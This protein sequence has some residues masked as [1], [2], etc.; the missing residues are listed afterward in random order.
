MRGLLPAACCLGATAAITMGTLAEARAQTGAGADTPRFMIEEIVVTARRREERLIDVPVSAT[1]FSGEEL[2][3]YNNV[4]LAEIGTQ[5]PN[6]NFI[7]IGSGSGATLMIRGLGSTSAEAGIEQSVI[8]NLDGIPM[9]R[10]RITRFSLFDLEALEV[11]KGPQ[12]LFFG[13]NSSAGV[14]SARSRGP[15]EQREFNLS[16]GHEFEAN[17]WF[18]EGVASGPVRDDLGIR[19]VVRHESMDG[20]MKNLA[21][22][23]A[24]PFQPDLPLPGNTSGRNR[25]GSTTLSGRLTIDYQPTEDFSLVFR[26]FG[27]DYE[28]NGEHMTWGRIRCAEGRDRPTV[29]GVESPVGDCEMN[30]RTYLSSQPVEVG[31]LWPN[32][33]NGIPYSEVEAWVLSLTA[34]Y[35]WPTA[36]FTSVTGVWGIDS[37][38]FDTSDG[39]NLIQLS[40]AN[41][42]DGVTF[43]QEFRLISDFSGP[44]NYT[45]GL[46]YERARRDWFNSGRI[47]PLPADPSTGKFHT[48]EQNS[49]LESE[50][51]S[52]YAQ[53]SWNL[54]ETME[55][56]GGARYSRVRTDVVLGNDFAHELFP[57][58][59]FFLP[60]G[61]KVVADRSDT[62]ISPELTLSWR[63]TDELMLFAAYKTGFKAGGFSL[64]GVLSGDRDENSSQFGSESAEGFELG[65]KFSLIDRRLS[66]SAS[67]FRY[68]FDD[69][70]VTQ[71]DSETTTFNIRNAAKMITQGVEFDARF[72]ITPNVAV[73]GAMAYNDA[74]FDSFPN[75]PCYTGQ[76][77]AEGCI[78]GLQDLSGFRP[79][80]VSK[81]EWHGGL[82][83]EGSVAGGWR[84]SAA[85]DA[86]W[87]SS[88]QGVNLQDPFARQPSFMLVD[89]SVQV[90]SPDER[91]MLGMFGRNL[92]N[93][94]WTPTA[95][96]PAGGMFGELNGTIQRTREI[97]LMVRYSL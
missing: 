96:I 23:I 68:T 31:A 46:F 10:G 17:E 60:V 72:W 78:D 21:E 52:G 42:E 8:F 26:A 1:V 75:A 85:A 34:D 84:L 48:W 89:A 7:S 65:A 64:P 56:A 15:G 90:S 49:K 33:N 44:W 16:V 45:T 39:T 57:V 95:G 77:A 86:R 50:T 28:D 13:K 27:V 73:R 41:N 80:S 71:F 22:P 58:P 25:P 35:S 51:F 3:R 88:Y 91:W 74:E 36:T 9:A 43:S 66:G 61:Q 30:T 32:V 63:P 59:G 18:V 37:R 20:W 67:V 12:A 93:K 79:G 92:T 19:L 62:D 83:Y 82:M 54:T 69:L 2:S 14:V 97:A 55:L 6:V 38:N 47:A 70:Q 5:I 81:W 24:N 87:R 4:G 76:T 40:G 94:L 11:L 29:F 53:L